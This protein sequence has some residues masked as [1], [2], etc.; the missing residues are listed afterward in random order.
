MIIEDRLSLGK[1]EIV[2]GLDEGIDVIGDG[3][4]VLLI[5]LNLEALAPDLKAIHLLNGL[6]CGLRV[7]KA[8]KA[9]PLGLAVLLG[10]DPGGVDVAEPPEEVVELGVLHVV[11][12]V[13]EEEVGTRRA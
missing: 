2:A 3:L 6:L 11:G 13:E 10:H 5:E 7:I 8:D 1:S 4:L 9:N 12:E